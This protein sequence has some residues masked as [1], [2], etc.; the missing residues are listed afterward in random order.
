[1]RPQGLGDACADALG[2]N[3]NGGQIADLFQIAALRER[4]QR[5]ADG[6][7][8]LD[9]AVNNAQFSGQGWVDNLEFHHDALDGRA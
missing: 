2:L 7:A 8:H 5:L 6:Q 4:T 3:Q 9:L 1:M